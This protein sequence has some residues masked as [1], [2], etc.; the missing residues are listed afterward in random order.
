LRNRSPTSSIEHSGRDRWQAAC[1]LARAAP[2]SIGLAGQR[3]CRTSAETGPLADMRRARRGAHRLR[4]RLGRVTGSF[5]S[6]RQRGESRQPRMQSQSCAWLCMPSGAWRL[7]CHL[8]GSTAS[9]KWIHRSHAL[10]ADPLPS[11]SSAGDQGSADAPA[12]MTDCASRPVE[13]GRGRDITLATVV[14]RSA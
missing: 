3:S 11:R 12:G 8:G 5:P 14:E 9:G 1:P 13:D 6:S 2:S 4:S 10:L 7:S